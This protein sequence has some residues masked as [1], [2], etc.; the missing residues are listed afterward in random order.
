MA[1]IN[2]TLDTVNETNRRGY[3][4]RDVDYKFVLD[5]RGY[6]FHNLDDI[7]AIR[8]GLVNIF[9][10][11]RGERIILPEFGNTLYRFLYESITSEVLND[12][13]RECVEMIT[14]WEPRISILNV[15]LE[16]FPDDHEVLVEVQYTIPTLTDA[17]LNFST[18]INDSKR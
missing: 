6:D 1:S 4:Y 10:W 2:I 18:I 14:R 11:R 7:N 3:T 15:N 17:Q 16:A 5:A 12:I 9:S 13:Q 8:N